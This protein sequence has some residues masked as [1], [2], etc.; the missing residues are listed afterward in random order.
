MRHYGILSLKIILWILGIII[1]LVLLL[2]V[3]IRVPAVQDFARNKAVNFLESKIGTKVEINK[4]SLNLPKLIVLED[5]YFE[6]QKKD[7]LLAGDTLKVDIS[8]LKLL[9]NTVEINEIDLRGITANVSRTPDSVFNFDYI[10]KAFVSEQAKP[11]PVDT[12]AAPMKFSIDKINLDRIKIKYQDAPTANDVSFYLGHFDTRIKEFDLDKMNFEIPKFRL[13]T[14]NA[15]VI[16]GKP[17]VEPTPKSQDIAEST[18]PMNLGLK[19]G[20]AELERIKVVYRNDV[21]ALNADVNLGK[22]NV[23]TDKLDLNNQVISLKDI[24]LDNS[25]FHITMGKKAETKVV[26]KEVKEETEVAASVWKFTSGS[27][28]FTNNDIRFDDQSLPVQKR[29]MDYGHLNIKNLSLDVSDLVYAQDTIAGKVNSGSM[30]EKSGF[31]LKRLSTNFFYGKDKAL[32]EDLHIETSRTLIQKEIKLSY[33]SIESLSSAPGELR[34]DANLDGSKLGLKDVLVFMPALAA[35]EPFKSHSAEVLNINGRINGQVKNLNITNFEL[36]GFGNTNLKASAKMVGL[37][38]MNKAR[39]DVK[40]DRFNTRS[41]DIYALV[42]RGTV[43]PNIR[44]PDALGLK[45]TFKGG[46]TAFNTN[47]NL[48]S[49]DGSMKVTAAVKNGKTVA[50]KADLRVYNLNAGR[51]MRQEQTIGKISLAAK[52]DLSGASPKTMNGSFAAKVVQAQYNKYNYRNLNVKGTARNGAFTAVA[53]MADPNITFDLNAKANMNKKYPSVQMDLNLDSLNL[54]KLN[55]MADDF[56]FHGKLTADIAT[57]DP[58]YLNGEIFLT[59]AILVMSGQRLQLDSINVVSTA[60]ADS[61]TLKLRSPIMNANV[62]GKYQLTQVGTAIQSVIYRYF[63]PSGTPLV[64]APASLKNRQLMKFDATISKHPLITQFVPALKELSTVKLNGNFDSQTGELNMTANAPRI[65]YNTFD[66]N[67]LVIEVGTEN[68]ALGYSLNL[69][70]INS[71]SLMLARTSITGD[72]QNNIISTDLR[73]RDNKDKDFYRLAGTLKAASSN[74]EFSLLPDGLMLNYTPWTVGQGNMIRFGSSGIMA[75]NFSLSNNNQQISINSNPQTV[76]SPLAVEFANFKIE[77]LTQIAT[78]DSL[79]AGGTI[80]GNALVRNL[81]SSPVFTSDLNVKDFSFMGDTVGN[82]ALKVNNEQANTLA[83]NVVINGKGNEVNLDGFYYLN[84]S[85]FDLTLDIKNLSMASI[86]GFTMGSLKNSRGNITGRLGITGSA[87][88]PKINGDVNFNKVGF[89]VTM[90][91]SD[92]RLED[93][94][95]QFSDPGIGFKDFKL[96]DSAGNSIAINGMVYTKT[97][98][99]FRFNLDVDASNFQALNSTAKDNELYYGKLLLDTRLRIRGDMNSPVV[100]GDLKINEGTK[101]T[102]VLPTTDPAIE[103]REGIV[104]FVDWDNPDSG[105]LTANLDTAS[106]SGIT[107]MNVSANLEIDENAEFNMIID[108]GNGDF[109]RLRGAAKLNA[110]IDPSGKTSLT[111]TYEMKEGAYEMSFNGLRR[112]FDIKPG[113]MIT[114]TGEPTAADANLTAIYEANTPPLDLVENFLG[115][116]SQAVLNTYKQK[117]PFQVLL[118]LKGELMKP[119]ISFD[120]QLPERNYNVSQSIISNVNTRLTQLR[121]E[122]SE[123]NKQVFAVLL[124]NRFVAENPFENGASGGGGVESMARQSVSKILSQQLNNLAGDLIGGVELNFDLESSEDYT[125]GEMAN[126]TDLNVGL[127]KRL[128]ND[129]LKVSVGSN[130]EVE[131]PKQAGQSANNIAGD[132]SLDYQLT[133]DGRYQLRAYRKNEYQVVLQGQVIETGVGFMINM[134]YNKFKEIFAKKTE[135]E[136]LRRRRERKADKADDKALN[137]DEI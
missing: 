73:V 136:K 121:S 8:L 18:E 135:E 123:L 107:G 30:Q 17:A 102:V 53:N 58:D 22:L 89:N 56:R 34:V 137:D 41:R 29:G 69:A 105:V 98:T 120:I 40:I 133:K 63:N 12:A 16:Q 21:S 95:I 7:T 23:E 129:R 100:D 124:L 119:E 15:V 5:I 130:F 43:P 90:L 66:L 55:L 101:L 64:A 75:T 81:D 88:A 109:L 39:F 110:G 48:N 9:K 72:I 77:T 122:P 86:Q 52:V 85:T 99:D 74:F 114:W 33:P 11:E 128:M 115:G 112:K 111:G 27:I 31:D 4:I 28:K 26:K 92:F 46:M 37:P 65:L 67:N 117:L 106:T 54:Q 10:I 1:F 113:S 25:A 78:K 36:S 125:T 97:F 62:S 49:S 91:N 14:V 59:D 103:E 19:L 82:I 3:L 61:N 104:E 44:I 68:N 38:D 132:V 93:E 35:T 51:I 6:D 2:F 45:G 80:N 108:A 127:S 84:S 134:D 47:L 76:N 87:S 57:A 70:R 50:Y 60:S 83:A 116:Q 13:S 131:G 126:R 94:R 79:L 118:N 20:E 42:P 96:L 24:L 32:L 71:P